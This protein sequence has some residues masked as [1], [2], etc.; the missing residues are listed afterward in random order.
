[1]EFDPTLPPGQQIGGR[2]AGVPN[3]DLD[4]RFALHYNLPTIKSAWDQSNLHIVNQVSY[5]N[6][7]QSHFTSQ[8]IYSFGVRNAQ[9]DGDGRGWLGRFADL[10][11]SN[12]SEPLGVISVGL[13]RRPDFNSDLTA[14]LILRD[15][16]SFQVD[17]DTEY[18]T[19]HALREK[20]MRDTI[21]AEP[22]PS[23]DPQLTI[24]DTSKQAYELVDRVQQETAGW[25]DPGTYPNTT[26]GRYL[27]TCSQL[28]HAQTSFGTKIFYTGF[29]GF[30]THSNEIDRHASLMAQ[31]NG[32][33]DAFRAD[34]VAKNKWN[35]CCI[36]VIS[37][38]GRRTF[39]NGSF[40]TDH[41]H[42]N[43]FLVMG[44]RV[45]RGLS[46]EI[47]ESDIDTEN[48][49]PFQVDFRDVYSEIILEH[50]GID[51][52]GMFPDPTFTP[53]PASLNII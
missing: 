5:P 20:V 35:N 14:P 19:D 27:R 29:G 15:V 53:D 49:V 52:A 51:P 16:A 28:L 6:P 46:A 41:G 10:N 47:T 4:G 11:C 9:S 39:E 45:R 25:V 30:D 2:P 48:H 22:P 13:G 24:F 17:V 40:G 7:N 42:G 23:E 33:I 34:M 3:H 36:V 38:F 1:N 37:E 31:L 18:V 44:G 43:A 26:L 21:G 32:G 50:L 8:D 12:P